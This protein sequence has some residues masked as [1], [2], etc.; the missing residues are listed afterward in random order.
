MSSPSEH[1]VRECGSPRDPPNE[2]KFC[3]RRLKETTKCPNHGFKK[4]SPKNKQEK[5][6]K[7]Y[8]PKIPSSRISQN[9]NHSFSYIQPIENTQNVMLDEPQNILYGVSY[10]PLEYISGTQEYLDH[11]LN[12]CV[13]NSNI[14]RF[15]FG[16]GLIALLKFR[17]NI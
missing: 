5:K 4:N 6:Q 9:L 16:I 7:S 11:F 13:D 12:K 3:K 2:E 15:L 10:T 1:S 14:K 8:V 17:M